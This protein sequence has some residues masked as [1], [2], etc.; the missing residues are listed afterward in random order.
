MR[1]HLLPNGNQAEEQA[2]SQRDPQREGQHRRVNPDL[3]DARQMLRTIGSQRP[4]NAKGEGEAQH[5]SG[6]AQQPAF[7]Q[8]IARHPDPAGAQRGAD[9]Q[10]L[11]PSIGAYQEQVRHVGAGNQQHNACGSHQHPQRAADAAHQLVF[12]EPPRCD[13]QGKGGR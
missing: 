6:H 11:P 7:Q 4:Q 9:R 1:A 2:R 3:V 12:Q 10:F 8:Q 5:A 13:V